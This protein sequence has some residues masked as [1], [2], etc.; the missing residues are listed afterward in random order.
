[1][2]RQSRRKY[3]TAKRSVTFDAA[4][5]QRAKKATFF[6]TFSVPSSTYFHTHTHTH[7]EKKKTAVPLL[8]SFA[9]HVENDNN[10]IERVNKEK[11]L[12]EI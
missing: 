1:M 2:R 11:R 7:R 10:S 3:K 6:S 12:Q 4:A 8:K 9:K 5:Q